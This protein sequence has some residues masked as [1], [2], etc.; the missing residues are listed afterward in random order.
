MQLPDER[1]TTNL[2]WCGHDHPRYVARF[3]GEW[4]RSATLWP[5]RV[6]GMCPPFASEREATEACIKYEAERRKD[7]GLDE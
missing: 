6:G 3:C 4:L 5:L 2:E 1:Y 7:M